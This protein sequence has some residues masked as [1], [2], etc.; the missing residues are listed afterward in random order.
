MS[1]HTYIFF[2]RAALHKMGGASSAE[3]KAE[4][5]ADESSK[6]DPDEKLLQDA[7]GTGDRTLFGGWISMSEIRKHG[8]VIWAVIF[9]MLCSSSM[10]LVNKRIMG[11]RVEVAARGPAALCHHAR[12]VYARAKV[13]HHRCCCGH[14]QRR[15]ALRTCYGGYG[16]GEGASRRVDHHG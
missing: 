1:G 12:H 16:E 13:F 3:A 10:L 7:V 2:S 4:P 8:D 11:R 9:F 14:T 15:A 6:P 5:T